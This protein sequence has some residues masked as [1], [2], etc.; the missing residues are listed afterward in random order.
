MKRIHP[1][2]CGV[3]SPVVSVVPVAVSS[4]VASVSGA[5]G[6]SSPVTSEGHV[7]PGGL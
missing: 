4:P 3:S 1:E 6:V 2:I 5:C 7:P